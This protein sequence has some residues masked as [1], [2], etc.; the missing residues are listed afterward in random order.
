MGWRKTGWEGSYIVRMGQSWWDLHLALFFSSPL[1]WNLQTDRFKKRKE[2]LEMGKCIGHVFNPHPTSPTELEFHNSHQ[3]RFFIG[4]WAIQKHKTDFITAGPYLKIKKI[5]K[6]VWAPPGFV[7]R[8]FFLLFLGYTD[9]LDGATA[10][11]TMR[12]ICPGA[13]FV[14]SKWAPPGFGW[15]VSCPFLGKRI[16]ME[17]LSK[18]MVPSVT[19]RSNGN[20]SSVVV[21]DL[22]QV[23]E[24]GWF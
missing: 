11:T 12:I 23:N 7:W 4:K 6:K 8:F 17:K 1:K 18:E 13:L 15:R 5:K 24:L 16:W 20:K 19:R 9:D 10:N 3:C 14:A 2:L 22:W 21:L